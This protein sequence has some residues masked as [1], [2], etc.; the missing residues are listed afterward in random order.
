MRFFLGPN[1]QTSKRW[2][3]MNAANRLL[4]EAELGSLTI[5]SE[6]NIMAKVIG[7]AI[8]AFVDMEHVVLMCMQATISIFLPELCTF[9]VLRGA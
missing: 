6:G 1:E 4:R 8:V 5:D 9:Y 2:S 3:L 7:V